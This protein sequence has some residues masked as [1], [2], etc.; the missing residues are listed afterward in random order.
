MGVLNLTPDSFSDGG[1]FIKKDKSFKHILDMIKSGAKIIDVGG[2]STR[3]GSKTIKPNIEWLR[4]KNVIQNFKKKYKDTCLSLDT[5]KS[6]L[7]K[8]GIQSVSYT[9]LTLPTSDLV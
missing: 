5:R 8:N 9:H 1:K 4:V 2:E 3:P 6:Y 7:M